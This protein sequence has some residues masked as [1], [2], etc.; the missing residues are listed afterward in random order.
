MIVMFDLT[1]S[2]CD[3]VTVSRR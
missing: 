1:V 3:Y 2:L